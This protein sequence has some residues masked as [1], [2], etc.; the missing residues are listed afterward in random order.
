[1]NVQF[2]FNM[3]SCKIG[4]ISISMTSSSISNHIMHL[5]SFHSPTYSN[6]SNHEKKKKKKKPKFV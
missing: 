4:T 5:S 1:M 6:I 3:L 2:V